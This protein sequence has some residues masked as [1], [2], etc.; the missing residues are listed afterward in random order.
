MQKINVVIPDNLSIEQELIE[1][2]KELGKNLLPASEK[3]LVGAG[4]EV[5][6]LQTQITIE[7]KPVEKP[8][9]TCKCSVC[10]TIFEKSLGHKLW[11][12]YGGIPVKRLYCSDQCRNTV[13]EIVGKGR[14][15]KTKKGVG[16]SRFW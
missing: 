7:R 8:I 13:M 4:Y 5:K 2:A 12:N 11:V 1:I 3:K 15:A 10:N 14:A 6:H 16:L 9:V